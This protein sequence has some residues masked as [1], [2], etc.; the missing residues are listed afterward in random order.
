MDATAFAP[1]ADLLAADH[2]VLT[3]DPRGI[4]RST[5]DEPGKDSTPQQRAD[6]L[7]RLITHVD[8]GKA[9]LL[10]SSGGAVSVLALAQSHPELVHTAIAHEPPLEELLPDREELW[11]QTEE[12]IAN[13][14]SGDRRT[15]W[16]QFLRTANIYL[17]DEVFEGMFGGDPGPQGLA[18]EHFQFAH[19][20]R[21]TT[22]FLPD[23][24]ALRS[25][26]AR[27]VVGIGEQSGGQLCD[28]ASRALAQALGVEPAMFPGGH[29]GFADDPA[30]FQARLREVVQS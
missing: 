11:A 23:I 9:A 30:G 20:L 1:L 27:V 3:T 6:D 7:A 25:G 18:D 28:R 24:D 29:I 14:L 15:A 8:A 12:M 5:V 22:R 21:A 2:T 26:P 19:M 17:P 10:G 4:N 13:Y 16:R